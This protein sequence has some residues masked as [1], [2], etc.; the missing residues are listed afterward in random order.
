M[1]LDFLF[2]QDL[3]MQKHLSGQENEVNRVGI[4]KSTVIGARTVDEIIVNKIDIATQGRSASSLCQQ[5]LRSMTKV[6]LSVDLSTSDVS[7]RK[8]AQLHQ[9]KYEIAPDCYC[10]LCS[11]TVYPRSVLQVPNHMNQHAQTRMCMICLKVVQPKEDLKKHIEESHELSFCKEFFAC[12]LCA[13]NL[14]HCMDKPTDILCQIIK[15]KSM[16]PQDINKKVKLQEKGR[17]HFNNSNIYCHV[18]PHK[19]RIKSDWGSL[20]NHMITYHTFMNK[21]NKKD[22]CNICGILFKDVDWQHSGIFQIICYFKPEEY[23]NMEKLAQV[24]CPICH[25]MC[26]DE[27]EV[28]VHS[29][30]HLS[31]SYYNCDVCQDGYRCNKSGKGSL[32]CLRQHRKLHISYSSFLCRCRFCALVFTTKRSR[33]EH[34]GKNHSSDMQHECKLCGTRFINNSALLFHKCNVVHGS[35]R[36]KCTDCSK[37][38]QNKRYLDSHVSSGICKLIYSLCYVCG[39]TLP[40]QCYSRH[41][42]WHE[43]KVTRCSL[44]PGSVMRNTF[45]LKK[46]MATAHSSKDLKEKKTSKFTCEYC[47]KLFATKMSIKLHILRH[48]GKKE[49]KCDQCDRAYYSMPS[50]TLHK[51]SAHTKERPFQC[52]YCPAAFTGLSNLKDHIR[53]HTGEKPYVCQVCNKAFTKSCNMKKHVKLM[54]KN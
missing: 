6:H 35:C 24:K 2:L 29:L 3:F 13:K 4:N 38:F 16:E 49:Y 52:S 51:R 27:Y 42:K 11:G 32:E 41:I 7:R 8:V 40:K 53:I 54:H 48:Q 33:A 21:E 26:A 19:C 18:C 22:H 14:M 28:Y 10:W 44:C 20:N 25:H 43:P 30:F 34:E 9:L 17:E 36:F 5:S 45:S 1:I 15:A 39:K 12:D 47:G 46:H 31:P 37:I 50:L 23:K